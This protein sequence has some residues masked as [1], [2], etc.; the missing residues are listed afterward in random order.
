[1]FLN[2]GAKAYNV[3][4]K[5]EQLISVLLKMEVATGIE[6]LSEMKDMNWLKKQ[7]MMQLSDEQ[8]DLWFREKVDEAVGTLL[9]QFNNY[10]HIV[11]HK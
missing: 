1:M 9:T 4:R 3:I 7:L 11:S 2:M 10:V 6:E 5:N 8:A